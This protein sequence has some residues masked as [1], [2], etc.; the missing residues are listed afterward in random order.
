MEYTTLCY[1]EKEDK[2]LMLY[3]N[4]KKN[5][6]NQGKWLGVGGHKEERE[7]MEECLLRE[8]YEETGLKLLNYKLC[9]ILH[10]YIDDLYEVSYL[11]TSTDFEGSLIDCS[12]GIL[13]WIPKS[14]VLNL[15]LWKGDY[16]FLNKLLNNEPYFEMKLVYVNDELIEWGYL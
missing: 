16:L 11:Y 6:I 10:F 2:Y 9:G 15:P 1:I 8:V 3:R 5:D 12:E 7:T 13:E 4:K 14:E